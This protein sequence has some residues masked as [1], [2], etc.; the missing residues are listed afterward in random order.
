MTSCSQYGNT[1]NVNFL[2]WKFCRKVIFKLYKGS[3]GA[4]S[5]CWLL[6]SS[7]GIFWHT[8][9]SYRQL[10]V[11]A[12]HIYSTIYKTHT[13]Q[14]M[15]STRQYASITNIDYFLLPYQLPAWNWWRSGR[16]VA[17][18]FKDFSPVRQACS[19]ALEKCLSKMQIHAGQ[20]SSTRNTPFPAHGW[21]CVP[22][23]TF[24]CIFFP[25][26]YLD[27]RS[28]SSTFFAMPPEIPRKISGNAPMTFCWVSL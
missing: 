21:W 5:P 3:T 17:R 4:S 26:L 9:F 2:P 6:L 22:I 8:C 13:P 23:N 10:R 15:L 7:A 12:V 16:R 19:N 24:F 25:F 28:I 11:F 27:C 1:V 18:M 20:G 14:Q